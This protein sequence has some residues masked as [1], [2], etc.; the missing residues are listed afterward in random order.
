[1]LQEQ[2]PHEPGRNYTVDFFRAQ[3]EKQRQFEIDI[4]Q[5]DREKKAQQAQFYER[6][7]ALKNLV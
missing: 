3:W 1:M 5:T 7:E 4:N 6:G 2:N